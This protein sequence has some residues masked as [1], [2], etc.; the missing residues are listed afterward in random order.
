[1]ADPIYFVHALVTCTLLVLGLFLVMDGINEGT[2][3]DH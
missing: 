3:V 2:D 1:M